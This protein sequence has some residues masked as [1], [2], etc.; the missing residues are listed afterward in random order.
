M[1]ACCMGRSRSFL[2]VQWWQ[3][4]RKIFGPAHEPTIRHQRPPTLGATALKYASK[5][6]DRLWK[7]EPAASTT[8]DSPAFITVDVAR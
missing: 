2:R 1:A 5:L 8:A 7:A 6:A 4:S 3:V